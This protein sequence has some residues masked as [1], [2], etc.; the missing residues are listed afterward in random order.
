[1]MT[2]TLS[3]YEELKENAGVYVP[4]YEEI[5]R[6]DQ[7]I[8]EALQWRDH[9]HAVWNKSDKTDLQCRQAANAL[10]SL[11]HDLLSAG[12]TLKDAEHHKIPAN[13]F[14]FYAGIWGLGTFALSL[15][16]NTLH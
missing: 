7:Q 11:W 10:S 5:Q 9:V 2:N 14:A 1:M 8:A 6:D 12:F 3:V 15:L 4:A 16:P 13:E